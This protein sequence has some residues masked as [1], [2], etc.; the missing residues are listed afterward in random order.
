MIALDERKMDFL[1][2]IY[3]EIALS[4]STKE[5]ANSVLFYVFKLIPSIRASLTLFEFESNKVSSFAAIYNTSEMPAGT[6]LPL[7]SFGGNIDRLSKGEPDILDDINEITEIPLGLEILKKDGLRSFACVPI[8]YDNELI[9]SIN[10]CNSEPCTYRR[11]TLEI[12]FEIAKPLAISLFQNRLIEQLKQ[13]EQV[14]E[15]C[16]H[17][18]STIDD[19]LYYVDQN[20]VY[21]NVNDAYCHFVNKPKELIVGFSPAEV[22][23]IGVFEKEIKKY[24][25]RALKGESVQYRGWDRIKG[26]EKRFL[27][28]SHYP[29]IDRSGTI[30]GVVVHIHDI[31]DQ[32]RNEKQLEENKQLLSK[33]FET[34]PV[35]IVVTTLQ[36]GKVVM[37]NKK[38]T[39]ITGYD[40]EKEKGKNSIELGFWKNKK[41]RQKITE[42][43]KSNGKIY[44]EEIVYFN[45]SGESRNAAIS[46]E[47]I[48]INDQS[49][50]SAQFGILPKK[51]DYR[52]SFGL[53]V[54]SIVHCMKMH[55]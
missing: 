19:P 42:L 55:R 23:G 22:I 8:C 9:G 14:L 28:I 30:L 35:G 4:K 6:V 11:E 16:H 36:E 10:V 12:L 25:D 34:S 13:R 46:V 37:A 33:I 20:M 1:L 45:K 50:L 31:T 18:I 32:K 2:N 51:R 27:E 7:D 21:Q 24:F 53:A 52:S 44:D 38:F 48:K 29:H 43:L 39:E 49:A 40:P 26:A 47:T 54:W 15:K 3:H 17:I 5:I 41:S